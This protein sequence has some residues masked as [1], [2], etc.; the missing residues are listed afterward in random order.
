MN[1]L[2]FMYVYE[3]SFNDCMLSV[4]GDITGDMMS[5]DMKYGTPFV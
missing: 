4:N 1:Q 2:Q 3:Y 5:Y